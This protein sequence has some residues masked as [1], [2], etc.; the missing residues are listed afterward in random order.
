[1]SDELYAS[2]IKDPPSTILGILR[3]LGPGMILAGS[4]VGSG[5]L[6]ATTRTGAEAGF[7][8][9]WLIIIGC[10][11]KVF[12]QVELARYSIINRKTTHHALMDI[13]GGRFIVWFWFLMFLVGIGQLGGIVGGVG[14]ALAISAPLTA[15]GKAYNTMLSQRIESQAFGTALA[16]KEALDTKIGELAPRVKDAKIW[17]VI[18]TAI[19]IIILVIGNFT[20]IQLFST[21]LVCGFT[22]ITIGNLF[23]LQ[24]HTEFAIAV[25]ELIKGLSFGFPEKTA[26]LIPLNTALATFGIIG[27]GAAEL[28]AYPYWCLEKGY[29]KWTGPRDESQAWADRARG[30]MRVMQWDAWCSMFV[31]TFSTV[32]FYLLGA[33]ILH[34]S[35][36][37]PEKSEMVSTLAVMYKPVFGPMAQ[38][39]FLVGAFAVLFSTFFVANAAKARL[40]SD[41]IGIMRKRP[42]EKNQRKRMVKLFSVILPA[43]CPLVYILYPN[44]LQ[45]VLI[46]GVMQALL[47]PMLG[48]AA[49]YYRYQRCDPRLKPGPIWDCW[50]WLSFAGF[51]VVGAHIAW[52]KLQG[53]F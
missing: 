24:G 23:A 5:E 29:A 15:E 34:R 11:I 14:Q 12:T 4:I 44:P 49:L 16:D 43:L 48:Y 19:T 26:G 13:P 20:W 17:A 42:Y 2:D 33:S 1:M 35:G 6:I 53:L 37:L 38:H 51:I 25:P 10:L 22:F 27:V 40:L 52:S 31:Y 46:A 9:L 47:L 3:Q 36:L 7:S 32:A 50:L 18:V 28:V 8:F 30:W 21:A 45:L 39:I 41:V